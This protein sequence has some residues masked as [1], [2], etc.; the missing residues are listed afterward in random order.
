MAMYVSLCTY[1]FPQNMGVFLASK[2]C[3]LSHSLRLRGDVDFS[4]MAFACILFV[5]TPRRPRLT[6][7]SHFF[8]SLVQIIH[9]WMIMDYGV[10]TL[11][12]YVFSSRFDAKSR[13]LREV[14]SCSAG[15]VAS[16]QHCKAAS[17]AALTRCAAHS[18]RLLPCT[19]NSLS[20]CQI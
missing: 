2:W 19:A 11:I 5:R 7:S 6:L 10:I 17:C 20:F 8:N 16:C 15:D 14:D 3:T 1:K 18:A 12:E 9:S 4:A 13:V